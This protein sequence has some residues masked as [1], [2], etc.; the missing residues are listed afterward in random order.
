MQNDAS[1]IVHSPPLMGVVLT[2][3]GFAGFAW[4]TLVKWS[5]GTTILV[6][7]QAA[8]P[9]SV[10]PAAPVQATEKSPAPVMTWA[11]IGQA[12]SGI[13]SVGGIAWTGLLAFRSRLRKH[14]RD[15]RVADALAEIKIYQERSRA[16]A[17]AHRMM[18]IAHLGH[19]DVEIKQIAA[20][21]STPTATPQEP[22]T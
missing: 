14:D 22:T 6:A 4:S 3:V 15:N 20:A 9:P 19:Q 1:T 5:V 7:A 16:E 11:E 12:F 17:E 8:P 10:A 21:V 13:V 2:A 18:I